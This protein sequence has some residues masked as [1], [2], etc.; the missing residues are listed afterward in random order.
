MIGV[1]FLVFQVTFA[2]G[3]YPQGWVEDGFGWLGEFFDG[4][5]A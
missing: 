1:L 5:P 3:A 2:L 4:R